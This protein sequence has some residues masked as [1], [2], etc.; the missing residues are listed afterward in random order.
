VESS[1]LNGPASAPLVEL[2]RRVPDA[3]FCLGVVGLGRIGLPLAVA[4]ALRD[5]D[6]RGLDI[7]PT[8]VEAVNDGVMPFV[9]QG[10][11]EAMAAAARSGR[12]RASV[13]SSFIHDADVI[14][15]SVATN[16]G[17]DLRT[18][19][20]QVHAA[21][22]QLLPHLRPGQLLMLR[23]TVTPDTLERVVIP[24]LEVK[25]HFQVGV[26]IFVA[27]TPE[28]ITAGHALEELAVLPEIVGA[29][30]EATAEIAAAVLRT[31]NPAKSVTLT[32]PTQ[33]ALA[34]LFSN[35]YRYVTFALANEF[36]LLGERYGADA[37]EV[38]RIANAGYPRAGIPRPG[39]AGGPCLPKDAHLLAAG[40]E[41]PD[42][43]IAAWRVNEG[44]PVHMVN[45]LENHLR[46]LGR[47]LR[48]SRVGV[49]GMAFKADNDDLRLSPA[50][51]IIDALEVAG[52]I[53]TAADPF[54]N[55]VPLED[56]VRE[57]D[58]VVL[59]TDHEAYRSQDV[60]E[61]AAR[62]RPDVVLLDFWGAWDADKAKTLGLDLVAIGRG[63]QT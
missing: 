63:H 5:I 14:I 17:P 29:Y 10:G 27:L 33:A 62:E 36:A 57:S 28:R 37:G 31:L 21:M 51:R 39:P 45:R 32:T 6:V 52:A 56:L 23:S 16:L 35:A 55:P 40:L 19:Y 2:Q 11:A 42:L 58:V 38:I 25:G 8:R 13:E 7:D 44:L 26:D 61:I 4:F 9:E 54:H 30:D 48:G 20:S 53:V 34:K 43:V 18:D 22:G 46:T 24:Y 12:L 50:L 47:R 60:L 15:L 41:Y 59:A 1:E 49:L 3:R